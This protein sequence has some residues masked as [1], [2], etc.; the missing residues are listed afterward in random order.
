MAVSD[1][2]RSFTQLR[3]SKSNIEKFVR[4]AFTNLI[5]STHLEDLER[6]KDWI[7][8]DFIA[9][10]NG[11]INDWGWNITEF[12]VPSVVVISRA[13]PKNQLI[14]A[15]KSY[16]APSDNQQNVQ[17]A[18]LPVESTTISPTVTSTATKMPNSDPFIESLQSMAGKFTFLRMLGFQSVTF[19]L[20]VAKFDTRYYLFH[21]TTGAIENIASCESPQ[22]VIR[23]KNEFDFKQFLITRDTNLIE[24]SHSLN[25]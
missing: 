12:S 20:E 13:E 2:V 17:A 14:D 10:C 4:L 9:N 3:D 24:I 6:K 11:S 15:L 21:T 22:V 23:F 1:A 25:I 7:M 16:F 19:S 18:Q 5:A 8:K